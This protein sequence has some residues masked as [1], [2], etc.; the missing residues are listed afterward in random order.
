MR[1]FF[2]AV[3]LILVAVVLLAPAAGAA[4]NSVTPMQYDGCTVLDIVTSS[5]AQDASE[6]WYAFVPQFAKML[7]ADTLWVTNTG[8]GGSDSVTVVVTGGITFDEYDVNPLI[9]AALSDLANLEVLAKIP[10]G[11]T[12]LVFWKIV[13]TQ[14]SATTGVQNVR[15]LL[16]E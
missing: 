8:P 6:T 7:A 15:I 2:H 11:S 4:S 13:V 1:V 12:G 16:P 9:S 14:L 10:G 5:L 3:A